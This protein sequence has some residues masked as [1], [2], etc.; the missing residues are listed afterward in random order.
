MDINEF[1][2]QFGLKIVPSEKES[3]FD[4]RFHAGI[5]DYCG[6]IRPSS[7]DI[8]RRKGYETA[9]QAAKLIVRLRRAAYLEDSHP[10]LF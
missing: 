8:V 10:K 7:D 1:L 2:S 9:S 4:E 3:T 6:G 5:S